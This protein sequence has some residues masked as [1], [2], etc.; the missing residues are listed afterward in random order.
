MRAGGQERRV[1]EMHKFLRY[2]SGTAAE[3]DLQDT[4]LLFGA[5]RQKPRCDRCLPYRRRGRRTAGHGW[6]ALSCFA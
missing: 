5:G 4:M 1:E 6:P 2:S 3:Q